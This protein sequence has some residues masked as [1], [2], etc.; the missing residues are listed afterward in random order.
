MEYRGIRYNIELAPGSDQWVWTIHV[1][2][3]K[4]GKIAGPRK[5][6][7]SAA[8]SAIQEWCYLH[9]QDCAPQEQV[10]ANRIKRW[11]RLLSQK[12]RVSDLDS[13]TGAATMLRTSNR[14]I[15]RS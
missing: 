6:A 12:K 2:L 10:V 3:P 8:R 4:Q 13:D 7:A 1:A 15:H 5:R 11:S 9:P 14:T